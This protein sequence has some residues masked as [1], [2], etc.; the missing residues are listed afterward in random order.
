MSKAKVYGSVN[1][2]HPHCS[3]LPVA[4]QFCLDIFLFDQS[5][6]YPFVHILEGWTVSLLN[7]K[8]IPLSAEMLKPH[9][10]KQKLFFHIK[11]ALFLNEHPTR[12]RFFPEE[13]NKI[14][15][16]VL[17]PFLHLQGEIEKV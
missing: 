5:R 14:L 6:T 12:Y 15:G 9:K 16:D 10:V 11:L 8:T 4:S 17:H 7:R 1:L 3:L 13:T 2:S